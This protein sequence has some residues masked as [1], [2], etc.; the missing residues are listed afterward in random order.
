MAA[1]PASSIARRSTPRISAPS[2]APVGITA[3][4]SELRAALVMVLDMPVLQ[5]SERRRLRR[6][7]AAWQ[8][9]KKKPA[10]LAHRWLPKS[11][12]TKGRL[13]LRGLR[14]G[15]LRQ[16]AQGQ[17]PLVTARRHGPQTVHH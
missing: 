8:P 7:G 12:R 4:L 15:D 11:V 17:R 16:S 1:K 10:A 6:D 14:V 5:R 9:D 3:K 2:A 13:L